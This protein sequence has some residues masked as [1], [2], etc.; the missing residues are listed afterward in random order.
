[1]TSADVTAAAR[2]TSAAATNGDPDAFDAAVRPHYAP[3]IRRLVLVLGDPHDA[4]GC[5]PGRIPVGVQVVD[6][7]DGTDVC[8]AL[9]HRLALGVQPPSRPAPLARGDRPIE[10]KSWTDPSDPD[11]WAALATLDQSTRSALL[12]NVLD[13]TPRLRSPGCCRCRRGRSRA[14]LAWSLGAA[15]ESIRAAERAV[16]IAGRRPWGD[17]RLPVARQAHHGQPATGTE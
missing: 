16:V 3:L 1:M 2:P 4:G 9:H 6:R 8:L 15:P 7:F 5:R 12:L 14:D 11:L 13:G 17:E 10:P